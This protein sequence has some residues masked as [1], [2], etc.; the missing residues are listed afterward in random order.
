M[1][2]QGRDRDDVR[3]SLTIE[4]LREVNSEELLPVG[5]IVEAE[6][7]NM[8]EKKQKRRRMAR[9]G[10]TITRFRSRCLQFRANYTE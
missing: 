1:D 8:I 10:Y 4:V 7:G 9:G 6:K 3:L 2:G 5:G